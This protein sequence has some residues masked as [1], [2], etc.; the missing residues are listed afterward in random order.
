MGHELSARGGGD[1]GSDFDLL[2]SRLFAVPQE[3]LTSDDYYTPSWI[4]ERMGIEFDLDVAS[5][6]GGVPWVPCKRFYT[7]TED[8]L[9]SE[10]AGRVWMNPPYSCVT[11]WV[12]RFVAHA[13][14]VCFVP[15]ARSRWLNVLWDAADGLVVPD[16]IGS[17]S[18]AN[19]AT[20]RYPV[21]LA[22]FGAE[23]VQA[24][25]HIGRVR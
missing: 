25:S 24:I 1:P 23:C 7:M 4:F 21:Y 22:A 16:N 17:F 9:T 6:P 13:D 12:A 5:P 20:M 3:Q 11:P 19:G 10:W 18:F 14:G 2:P 15:F 8:G